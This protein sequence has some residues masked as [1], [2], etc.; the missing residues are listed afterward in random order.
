MSRDLSGLVKEHHAFYEV[1]PYY[2]MLEEKHGSSSA[3]TQKLQAGFDVDVYGLNIKSELA[4]PGPDPDYAV[5]CAGL[6]KIAEE[7]SH[8]ASG[9]CFLEVIS[10]PETMVFDN[11]NLNTVEGMVKI[12]ISHRRGLDQAADL[13]EQQALAEIEKQL[14]SLGVARR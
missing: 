13:P 4:L 11:R 1:L 3:R 12:R 8:H 2:L 7:V 6:E 14:H 9:S 10:F 5:G